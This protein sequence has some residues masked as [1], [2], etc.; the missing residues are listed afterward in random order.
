VTGWHRHL[1]TCQANLPGW[2]CRV[3]VPYVRS[4]PYQQASRCRVQ[5]K[6]VKG[7]QSS[8]HPWQV[9]FGF[10]AKPIT[11]LAV[12]KPITGLADR[13]TPV[14]MAS[15]A[16]SGVQHDTQWRQNHL[17][18]TCSCICAASLCHCHSAT[19][20]IG[21]KLLLDAYTCSPSCISSHQVTSRCCA[22]WWL[23]LCYGR[24]CCC[25]CCCCCQ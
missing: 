25:C 12:A 5:T 24:R 3:G 1:G 23:L 11:G 19:A 7:P 6:R 22:P 2:P 9:G 8:W 15:A 14:H 17:C 21:T 10:I 16:R 4:M 13:P 18:M 20:T